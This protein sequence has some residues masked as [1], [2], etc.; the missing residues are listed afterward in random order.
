MTIDEARKILGD[1]KSAE[2]TDDELQQL[3]WDLTAIARETLKSIA[4]GEFRVSDN[5]HNH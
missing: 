1:E 4:S 2:F 5:N 3:I